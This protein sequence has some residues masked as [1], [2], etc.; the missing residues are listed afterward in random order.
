M[1]KIFWHFAIM[2]YLSYSVQAQEPLLKGAII[3]VQNKPIENVS[4]TITGTEIS[5]ATNAMGIFEIK[6]NIGDIALVSHINFK[7]KLF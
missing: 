1:K 5:T 3:D 4:L 7:V 6:A 2:L